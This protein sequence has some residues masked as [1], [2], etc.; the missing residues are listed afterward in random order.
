ME[1]FGLMTSQVVTAGDYYNDYEMLCLPGVVSYCPENSPDDIKRICRES[2][3][4]VEDGFV[5]ELIERL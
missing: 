5:A 1:L 4:S 2:L 3:C